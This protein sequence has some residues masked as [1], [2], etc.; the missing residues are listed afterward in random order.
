MSMFKDE[1][2][3][4]IGFFLIAFILIALIIMSLIGNYREAQLVESCYKQTGRPDHTIINKVPYCKNR[5]GDWVKL[6]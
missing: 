3:I 6:R 2:D 1:K 5:K 4:V